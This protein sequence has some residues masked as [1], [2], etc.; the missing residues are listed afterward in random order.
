[1]LLRALD[2]ANKPT[3]QAQR[4]EF[5]DSQR[6]LLWSLQPQDGVIQ[7]AVVRREIKKMTKRI[8]AYNDLVATE[9]KQ[10]DVEVR[11]KFA[12]K[13]AEVGAA[14]ALQIAGLRRSNGD[15]RRG[16]RR[17]RHTD[18]LVCALRPLA[19]PGTESL[20]PGHGDVHHGQPHG[21]PRLPWAAQP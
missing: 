21:L 12:F 10:H 15:G 9:M 2:L 6:S 13:L 3:F 19:V 14:L 4:D 5:R 1:M 8:G 18:H 7:E 16:H 11:G 17:R 20:R